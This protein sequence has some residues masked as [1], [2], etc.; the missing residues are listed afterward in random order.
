MAYL[1][2]SQDD[3]REKVIEQLKRSSIDD[4]EKRLIANLRDIHFDMIRKD[5]Y[6]SFIKNLHT[7]DPGK[8]SSI[9][10]PLFEKDQVVGAMALVFFSSSL[11]VKEAFK[12]YK[13]LIVE[14]QK[15]IN[16]DLANAELFNPAA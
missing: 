5:G 14:T 4:D 1:A 10:L 11:R 15:K 16:N 9:A 7:K 2:F 6:A 13:T 12:K 3:E 8:T